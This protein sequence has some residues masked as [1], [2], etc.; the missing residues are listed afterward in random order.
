MKIFILCGGSGTRLWPISRTDLPKQFAPL[1]GKMTLFQKTLLR[2]QTAVEALGLEAQ[3]CVST[4]KEHY[5][6]AKQQAQE[7]GVEIS[8]FLLED[9]GRDSAAALILGALSS[10]ELLLALPSDHII[11]DNEAFAQNLKEALELASQNRIVT[12]GIKPTS[13]HTGYGYI[14]AKAQEVLGFYEKPNLQTAQ[15][16][17]QSGEYFFNSGMFCFQTKCF[18]Q[19]CQTHAPTL[20][21]QCQTIYNQAKRQEDSISLQMRG[22]EKISIDYALMEKSSSLAMVE[23][24]F[25]WNDVGNFQALQ[26]EFP[27][28]SNENASNT[29]I[30]A[31]DAHQNFVLADKPVSLIGTQNLVVV[32][33]KDA[34]LITTQNKAQ[35]VKEI[36]EQIKDTPIVKESPITH[37]PWGSYEVLEETRFYKIKKIIVKPHKR[38]SLQKHFHRNEHW[39]VVSG[40][41]LV[42]NGD[43]EMFLH[44]NQSTYIPMGS[45]HRLANPGKIDLV[46]IEVQMGEY[47]GEDDIVRLE[48]DFARI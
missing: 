12:F 44:S 29:Q 42:T 10:Q 15:Q 46:L 35:E 48:D 2:A 23:A 19:E 5:F 11:N 45:P 14:H 34:L 6:L 18:L 8:Q 41:A 25:D 43:E 3:I 36:V 26:D 37:R 4:N 16:Y 38:L 47:V 33:T 1:F 21:Q 40:S 28:D 31:K 22:V 9:E 32:D 39:I 24:D 17:L 27:C 30:F 20:L 7:I 13:P